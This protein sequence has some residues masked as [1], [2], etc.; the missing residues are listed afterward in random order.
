MA[1]VLVYVYQVK[2]EID[3]FGYN[4]EGKL[5]KEIYVY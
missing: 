3:K 4:S 2:N 1:N 5:I